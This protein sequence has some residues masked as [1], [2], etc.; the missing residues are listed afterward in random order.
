MSIEVRPMTADDVAAVIAIEQRVQPVPWSAS[1]LTTELAEPTRAYRCAVEDGEILGY[2]G[3]LLAVDEAHITTMATAPEH[4]H[5]GVAS[6]VLAALL[7]HAVA[8]GATAA[9]LEVRVSNHA[10][11]RLYAAFGFAPVGVRPGYYAPE[12]EDAMI[13]WVHDVDGP[14]FAE[15]LA[16]AARTDAAGT[17]SR[18]AA[19]G[20][21]A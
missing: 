15:R 10:A 7:D 3:V 4:R 1:L 5:R 19:R 16:R 6:M 13:M 9:T 14:V 12:G 17:L 11:Q 8:A 18:T 21:A 2:G 20:G